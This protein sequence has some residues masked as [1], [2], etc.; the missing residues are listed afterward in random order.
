MFFP[1]IYKFKK[2]LILKNNGELSLFWLGTGSAFSKILFQNNF[3]IIKSDTHLLVDCG[4]K[5]PLALNNYGSSVMEIKNYLITHSHADHIGGLEEVA[6]INR[7]IA[8]LKPNIIIVKEYEKILW[9]YSLK[10]GCA[11]N[12]I[13][14]GDYLT[15]NDLFNPIYPSKIKNSE[16][17]MYEL[18]FKNINLK[19]FRTNHVPDS[20]KSW[21]D[22][23]L[24]YGLIIDEKI[25]FTS[26]T[27][28]DPEL[29]KFLVDKYE[30]IQ[31]IFHD[32][33]LFKGGVHASYEE[34]KKFPRE[35]KNKIFLTHYQDNFKK[36]NA[37]KDGF[38]GFTKEGYYYTFL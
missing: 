19:F 22:A 18:E 16:R 15:F 32:C 5:C 25:L 21:K 34:L 37:E 14:K 6:L 33:Q 10:G 9:D 35:I 38:A 26:D 13:I 3:L 23:F 7:Y 24:S 2:K 20:S 17:T 36:F 30:N 4:T 29:I 11:F 1:K 27:K 31:Y 12:E 8:K 28:H